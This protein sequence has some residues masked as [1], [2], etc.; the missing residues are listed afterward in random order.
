MTNCEDIQAHL[1]AFVDGGLT[2]QEHA[3]VLAHVSRCADCGGVLADL[4]RLRTAARQLGPVPPPEHL[5]L[6]VAGHLRQR[7]RRD[8]TPV[9][10]GRG[11]ALWQ[12]VGLSAALLAITAAI[13]FLGRSPSPP[14]AS[15]AD[16]APIDAMQAVSDE[17]TL[18]MQHYERAIAGLEAAARVDDARMDPAVS[19]AVRRSLGSIDSAISESRAALATNPDSEP[20]RDSLFEALRRKVSVLQAT[21]S[22]I[23]EMR[24]GDPAGATRA[25][26]GLGRQS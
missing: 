3:D 4:E 19:A 20:A 6:E 24:Q 9:S 18:A 5:W 21:V 7:D 10:A 16:A 26:E 14:P 22:L 2:P 12:W 8:A 15:A 1:S 13:Y 11:R 17:L 25:M 23:N